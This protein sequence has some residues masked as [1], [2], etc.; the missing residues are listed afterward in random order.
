MAT[1]AVFAALGG[2]AY[3]ATKITGRD[4]VNR[5]LTGKDIKK[6][7]VP[8]NR[9]KGRPERGSQGVPGP[10]GPKGDQGPPGPIDPSQF[11]SAAG[12]TT[13]A[14][15]PTEWLAGPQGSPLQRTI[16]EASR[17]EWSSPGAS[18]A[19]FLVLEPSLP[20]ASTTCIQG[21]TS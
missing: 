12:T 4:V 18:A 7:S 15:G 11:L 21:S 10:Q 19:A 20:I 13:V 3:A 16:V 6:R 2:G 9:L 8:L 17:V 5:S 1:I 14:L